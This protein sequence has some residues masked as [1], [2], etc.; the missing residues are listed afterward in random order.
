MAG[1]VSGNFGGRTALVAA[2]Q[3]PAELGVFEYGVVRSFDGI[4]HE[5]PL[6]ILRSV[7]RD[8]TVTHFLLVGAGKHGLPAFARGHDGQQ[9]RFQGSLIQKDAN[10]MIEPN[11][12]ASFTVLGPRTVSEDGPTEA[13][14]SDITLTGELVDTKCHFGVMRPATEKV[15]RACAVRCLSGGV[16]PGLLLRDQEGSAVVL[17]ITGPGGSTPR[18][19]LNSFEPRAASFG[20]RRLPTSTSSALRSPAAESSESAHGF[21]PAHFVQNPWVSERH[22]ALESSGCRNP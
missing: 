10:V 7:S 3:T 16:P 19:I 20:M 9:G 21:K 14:S 18:G 5:R 11:D 22:G 15:H 2:L 8:G 1:S 17:P 13:G 12:A 4:L 6:P